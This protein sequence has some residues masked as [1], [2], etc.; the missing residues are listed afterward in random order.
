MAILWTTG[1]K[2]QTDYKYGFEGNVI[3]DGWRVETTNNSQTWKQ[4]GKHENLTPHDGNKQ[5][6]LDKENS[7]QDERLISPAIKIEDNAT[8][9]FWNH[10]SNSYNP[11]NGSHYNVEISTD[12]GK[13]WTELWH[14]AGGNEYESAITVNLGAYAGKTVNISWRAYDDNG[15][16]LGYAWLIDDITVSETESAC[17]VVLESY[18]DKKAEVINVVKEKLGIE[19]QAAEELVESAPC[20]LKKLTTMKD[21]KAL[22]NAI[23]TAGG[24]AK[25]APTGMYDPKFVSLFESFEEDAI[26]PEGWSVVD[27]DNDGK[28]WEVIRKADGDWFVS[29]FGDNVNSSFSWI[30]SALDPDNYLIS[31]LL[32]DAAELNYWFSMNT[33]EPDHYKVLAST[34]G[35]EVADFTEVLVDEKP[36]GLVK[37]NTEEQSK[38][39]E[40]TLP[41][42]AGTKYIAFRHCESKDNN[43]IL[44]DNVRIIKG[45]VTGIE[46]LPA[47]ENTV[48]RKGIYN[49]N[50]M[51]MYGEWEK[52]PKGVYVV[53]GKKKVK[54]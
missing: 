14:A 34:T 54:N 8:L 4:Y 47:N 37:I 20:I 3:A 51:K 48:V 38:W 39:Y 10:I 30:G 31:P 16:G 11:G 19:L 15:F 40:R 9:T 36:Q 49:I 41:L 5:M 28:Q 29:F 24:K 2:A 53:D 12:N 6:L 45:I 25:M 17:D 22:V 27:A 46:T 21:A 43:Y 32:S 33:E 13:T 1:A 18:K 7:K 26:V 35:N 42:P 23:N 50:G 44:I 52:M